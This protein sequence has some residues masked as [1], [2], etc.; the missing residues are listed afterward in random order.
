VKNAEHHE[1]G[2]RERQDDFERRWLHASNE[3]E[4]SRQGV[5][6]NALSLFRN[7]AVGFIDWLDL[8]MS[9]HGAT[10]HTRVQEEHDAKDYDLDHYDARAERDKLFWM[11]SQVEGREHKDNT[12]DHD[13]TICSSAISPIDGHQPRMAFLTRHWGQDTEKTH[14]S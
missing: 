7:G 10:L 11:R 1:H 14:K 5:V 3:N 6:P 2:A 12:C 9:F 4:I 8:W 13:I